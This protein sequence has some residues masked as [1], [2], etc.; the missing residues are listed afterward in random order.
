MLPAKGIAQE[1]PPPKRHRKCRVVLNVGGEKFET[2]R[3]TL[4]GW[5]QSFFGPLASGRHHVE[6]EEDGSLFIDRNPEF[7]PFILEYL[8]NG[9]KVILPEKVE[10]RDALMLEAEYYGLDNLVSRLRRCRLAD[11]YLMA[12]ETPTSYSSTP[13]PWS[14]HIAG[15]RYAA[16][17]FDV[18]NP[19]DFEMSVSGRS[20]DGQSGDDFCD[21][22]IRSSSNDIGVIVGIAPMDINLSEAW[23]PGPNPFPSRASSWV[24]VP[25]SEA[26]SAW[27]QQIEYPPALE[28]GIFC[29][30]RSCL[31]ETPENPEPDELDS[32]GS[33]A[34]LVLAGDFEKANR[35]ESKHCWSG[36]MITSISFHFRRDASNGSTLDFIIKNDD[37]ESWSFTIN[38]RKEGLS[39]S[40]PYRPV[41]FFGK[42]AHAVV[43][44]ITQWPADHA[45]S[46]HFR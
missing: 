13:T 22:M 31:F 30:V 5:P 20:R 3:D 12:F 10:I 18:R 29:V 21:L 6:W 41:V 44:D 24:T 15:S 40:M 1:Q 32:N 19:D 23:V 9:N 16:S 36:R 28:Q 26:A 46:H 35:E 42:R 34:Q 39:E 7:F 8:R 2:S 37:P 11:S 4:R 17:L 33:L 14:G 45:N 43:E 25:L 38:L 27:P